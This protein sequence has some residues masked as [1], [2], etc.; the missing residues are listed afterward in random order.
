MRKPFIRENRLGNKIQKLELGKKSLK[1]FGNGNPSDGEIRRRRSGG[2]DAVNRRFGRAT[3][4][5]QNGNRKTKARWF[6]LRFDP[7]SD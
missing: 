5:R 7:R 2:S 3:M 4:R 6:S 1:E